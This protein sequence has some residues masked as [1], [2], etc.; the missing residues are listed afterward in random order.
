LLNGFPIKGFEGRLLKPTQAAVGSGSL[1]KVK[2]RLTEKPI[3]QGKV[4]GDCFN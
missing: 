2:Q 1:T 4:I 3:S